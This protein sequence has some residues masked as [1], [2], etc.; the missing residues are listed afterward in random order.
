MPGGGWTPPGGGPAGGPNAWRNGVIAAP[1]PVDSAPQAGAAP[2]ATLGRGQPAADTRWGQAPAGLMPRPQPRAA[3]RA[4]RHARRRSVVVA[5]RRRGG[6][7]R[8]I[9]LLLAGAAKAPGETGNAARQS[10][11][12][13][14][15]PRVDEAV[16]RGATRSGDPL[17]V[18]LLEELA[19]RNM[20]GAWGILMGTRSD[21][22]V[23]VRCAALDGLALVAPP[24][25]EPTLRGWLTEATD[26]TEQSHAVR[27]AAGADTGN[28]RV[29]RLTPGYA[30]TVGTDPVS[31]ALALV[32]A[33]SLAQGSVAPG[34][35]VTIYGLGI[36]PGSGA[37]E[38]RIPRARSALYWRARR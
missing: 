30:V 12:R 37:A 13:L 28:N 32:N 34:E 36:G 3:E 21:P 27:A 1:W 4:E 10:H 2:R 31:G 17:R 5:G 24:S 14:I 20:P 18:V 22:A 23:P 8:D 35:I 38:R 7:P 16:Y 6:S 29:R 11:S 9:A 25:L 15:G 26:P 33:A 19:L